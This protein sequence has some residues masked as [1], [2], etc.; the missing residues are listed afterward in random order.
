MA[1]AGALAG[2]HQTLPGVGRPLTEQEQL[3]PRFGSAL[4]MAVQ[5]G[6]DDLGVVDDQHVTL[7]DVVEN[8]VKMLVVNGLRLSVQHHETG[9]IPLLHGMLGDQL[10]GEVV[11]E[12][13]RPQVRLGTVVYD[14][15]VAHSLVLSQAHTAPIPHILTADGCFF[16]FPLAIYA[17]FLI[18]PYNPE[19]CN[20]FWGFC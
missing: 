12:I 9:V 20:G 4:G 5:A 8:I 3:D 10:L 14:E 7:A 2:L 18:I 11:E 13:R 15:F 16:P 1:E 19:N 6:G 17:Q